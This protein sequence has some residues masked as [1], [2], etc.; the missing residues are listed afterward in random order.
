MEIMDD[1]LDLKDSLEDA[2]GRQTRKARRVL[3][4]ESGFSTLVIVLVIMA[5]GAI[6]ITPLLAFVVVGTRAGR[7]H[8]RNTDRLYAADAGIQDGLWRISSGDYYDDWKGTW[9]DSVFD[10]DP[11][12]YS[13]PDINGCT[14]TVTLR[15]VWLL[16]GL[17]TPA[18]GRMPHA[19]LV[20]V[21]SVA[22]AGTLQIVVVM[23][24]SIQSAKKLDR[25][26]VWLPSGF[27]Y[28][29]GSSSLEDDDSE[30]WYCEP[31][32]TEWKS[33]HTVIWDYAT[34]LKFED[35]PNVDGERMVIS[36][37]YTGEGAMTGSWSWTR[38]NSNDIYLSWSTDIKIFQIESTAT[39]PETGVTTTVVAGNM[40]NESVGTYL[41]YYGD[42][43]VT[44]NA[45]MREIDTDKVRERLYLESPGEI[46]VI[47]ESATVRRILLYWSGWKED[48]W[49]IWDYTADERL[50]LAEDA[51]VTQVSLRAV[52]DGDDYDLGTV[53]AEEWTVL[54]N[55]SEYSPNGWS[56]GCN[57]DITNLV[58]GDLPDDF[59]GNATYWVGHADTTDSPTTTLRGV[60][61]TSTSNI[62]AVGE[63][64]YIAHCDGSSWTS[65]TSGATNDL[66][67][68]WGSSASNIFAVGA[69]GTILRYDGTS[70]SAMTSG[71]TSDLY[72]VWGSSA[73]NVYAVGAGGTIRKWNGTTWSSS[74]SGTTSNLYGIWGS[75]SNN[76][77]AV[78]AGGTIRKY[79]SSWAASSSGTT[80]T[81]YGIWGS[82]SSNIFAVGAGGTIRRYTSYWGNSGSGTTQTLYGVWG[83]GSNN[84]YAV[85]ASGTIRRWNGS[86]WGNSNSGTTQTLHGA[87]G[88]NS[89]NI[90]AVGAS[91]TILF[92]NGSSWS[93]ASTATGLY[94][95][96]NGHS[97]ETISAS[98]EYPL[99]D[100]VDNQWANACWSIITLYTSPVTLAHQMYLFDTFRYWNSEDDVEFTLDGF[101]AP[102]GIADEDDAVRLTYFVGEGDQWYSNGDNIYLNGTQLNPG[103][104]VSGS[105]APDDNAMNSSSDSGGVTGYPPDDGIDLDTYSID[106]SEGI[107][108]PADTEATVRLTTGTDVW[109]LIYMI[110]SFRSD[111]VGSGCLT[112]VVI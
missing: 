53:T 5:V 66:Y 59:A 105:A 25:I 47:P 13:V 108:D 68:I 51:G 100:V 98:T 77:Y 48:P 45:L 63:D 104:S 112:Y 4:G 69:G 84:I 18:H 60:W 67:G 97:G 9:D 38:T 37:D 103:N 86:F 26:G 101:L 16:D 6:I 30:D 20:T 15:P 88:T 44:G 50:D 12:T 78:G 90:W 57:C 75:A 81:L 29:E 10:S 58:L 109:N 110:L 76:I 92:N 49:D 41:A 33:G 23:D 70:W 62:Y 21:S 40:L 96:V 72:G 107:I 89:N 55:G 42:Y 32:V 34:A 82:S 14:V 31:T 46:S 35:F 56:Y 19:E 95:W 106:G 2:L 11:L 85:G 27:D 94:G 54:P 52:Y 43:E 74:S 3:R 39:D 28:V 61:G 71:T 111:N 73:T 99:S 65:M 83:S 1:V 7:V 102:K 8:N 79:T 36:L 91:G 80:Q 93:A 24:E 64:G 87:W 17:E 22:S